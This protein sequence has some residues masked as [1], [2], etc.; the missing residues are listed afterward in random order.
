MSKISRY[1]AKKGR[2]AELVWRYGFNFLPSFNYSLDFSK[3]DSKFVNSIVERLNRD[4]VAVT[5]IEECSN[6]ILHFSD[7][8]K[9]VDEILEDKKNEIRQMKEKSEKSEAI[10]EKTF[11]VELLGSPLVFDPQSIFSS[12]ALQDT[13]LGIANAYFGMIVK[14]RYYNVWY[15]FAT[16]SKARESQ[17]WHFD[18]EDN[19]ILKM[20]LYLNDVDE[21]AGPFTYAPRTHR[22]GS[23]K[24]SQPEF[25]VEEGVQRSTDEQMAAVVPEDKWIKGVGKKGTIIFADTRGFHK[26]G[27]ARTGDR[28]MYTCMF[29]SPA[30]ESKQLL[31]FPDD[32]RLDRLS[33]KQIAALKLNNN[34]S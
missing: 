11:N 23:L 13:L 8:E 16:Q 21:G 20:F 12:F 28:L 29:T 14:L 33:A 6:E 32:L 15:T 10:G 18:R 17:L 34:R 27:E 19:Y 3:G 2:H 26:G 4:G 5:S 9:A 31:N 30:S 24:K 7:L 1:I 25:F 22:K